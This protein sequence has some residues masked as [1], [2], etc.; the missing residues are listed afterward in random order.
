[1][2]VIQFGLAT[3]SEHADR[4]CAIIQ[5]NRACKKD[6]CQVRGRTRWCNSPH[7]RNQA[8]EAGRAPVCGDGVIKGE[9]F[10]MGITRIIYTLSHVCPP[11]PSPCF[12]VRLRIHT[13]Q[14][15]SIH[16]FEKQLHQ[17]TCPSFSSTTQTSPLSRHA[18][19]HTI[20]LLLLPPL[21]NAAN[22]C[23][24][25]LENPHTNLDRICKPPRTRPTLCSRN[26]RNGIDFL[27]H[28]TISALATWMVRRDFPSWVVLWGERFVFTC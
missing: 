22:C 15:Q 19:L 10:L 14:E 24:R 16:A 6:K 28:G 12:P 23:S 17:E 5:V 20:T 27:A 1:L 7:R 11:S 13:A 26:I 2:G 8:R 21:L 4:I 18:P 9:R 25:S 3:A